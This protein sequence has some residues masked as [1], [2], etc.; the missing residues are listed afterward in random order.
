M[1]LGSFTLVFVVF[2]TFIGL[3]IASKY[4]ETNIKIFLYVGIGWVGSATAWMGA[5]YNFLAIL[6]FNYAPPIQV[7]LII[8]GAFLP[9]TQLAWIAAMTELT[10][11]NPKKRKVILIIGAVIVAIFEPVYLYL[12]FTNP[13]VIGTYITPIQVDYALFSQ[14]HYSIQII[15]FILPGLWLARIS[16]RSLKPEIKLK[17][18]FLLFTFLLSIG[19][20]FME[21]FAPN[22]LFFLIARVIA[23]I[24]SILFYAGFIL[25]KLVKNLFLKQKNDE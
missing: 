16:L 7:Y 25:P 14:I 6:L 13:S 4:F 1:L 17:G 20:S 24:V 9:F 22:I 3:R 5:A 18:K 19:L 11:V 10:D 12:V 21:L 23:V 15:V 2:Q 8:C